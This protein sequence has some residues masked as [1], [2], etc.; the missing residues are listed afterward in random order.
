[1]S[2]AWLASMFFG[3]MAMVMPGSTPMAPCLTC[4]Q[5]PQAAKT[6]IDRFSQLHAKG[7]IGDANLLELSYRLAQRLPRELVDVEQVLEPTQASG[8]GAARNAQPTRC[9]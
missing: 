2:I 8:G 7:L 4:L 6:I 1:M 3:M 9:V 5:L